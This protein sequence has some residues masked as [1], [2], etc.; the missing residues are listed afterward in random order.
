MRHNNRNMYPA[1]YALAG[2]IVGI[3][4]DFAYEMHARMGVAFPY[5]MPPV[6]HS[7]VIVRALIGMVFGFGFAMIG[8]ALGWYK[9]DDEIFGVAVSA[10]LALVPI[11]MYN[12]WLI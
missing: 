5:T 4:A 6:E 10:I 1:L 9:H 2:L 3:I 8:K 12:Q 7:S 11:Y